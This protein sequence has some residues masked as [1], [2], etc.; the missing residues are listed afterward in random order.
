MFAGKRLIEA[1]AHR[2]LIPDTKLMTLVVVSHGSVPPDTTH[3]LL[4]VLRRYPRLAWRDKER[5]SNPEQAA[6]KAEDL[7]ADPKKCCLMCPPGYSAASKCSVGSG[8]GR[9][10]APCGNG[11]YTEKANLQKECKRCRVCDKAV[12]V[13][14]VQPCRSNQDTQCSCDKGYYEFD[15]SK[16]N[17]VCYKCSECV[18]RSVSA[19]CSQKSDTKCGSCDLGFYQDQQKTCRPCAQYSGIVRTKRACQHHSTTPQT[20]P[21]TKSPPE[22]FTLTLLPTVASSMK[23]S[24]P[25]PH[26]TT[27]QT[28]PDTKSPTQGINKTS[29]VDPL[30]LGFSIFLVGIVILGS[31]LCGFLHVCTCCEWVILRWNQTQAPKQ[32]YQINSVRDVP[33][34]KGKATLSDQYCEN[35]KDPCTAVSKTSLQIAKMYQCQDTTTEMLVNTGVLSSAMPLLKDTDPKMLREDLHAADSWPPAVLYAI[36]REVPARRW[37][38]FLRLL[39]VPDGHI[40]RV[41]MEVGPCYLEQ[42]YQMLRLWSQRG[43]VTLEAVYSALHSMN[44]SG[45]AQELQEK[46]QQLQ[47]QAA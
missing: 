36:I 47:Q 42:Q 8:E 46:L 32:A 22:E 26:Y 14:Q 31:F 28:S 4:E 25:V 29:A 2:C 19:A 34:G 17:F 20:P 6:C 27:P 44:L 40:E 24:E 3:S 35:H 30:L 1:R 10:C 43:G 11:T 16:D 38:E 15:P 9:H 5:G 41:E 37:K 23:A 13:I 12:S 45:C 21:S 18:N 33:Q 39:S 7:E